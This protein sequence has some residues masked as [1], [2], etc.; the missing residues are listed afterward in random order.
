[1]LGRGFAWFDSGTHDSLQQASAFVQTI[2]QRQNLKI[3][4]LEEIAF[5]N[6]FISKTQLEQAAAFHGKGEYGRY[7]QGLLEELP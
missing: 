3:A 5:R 4:C 2:E 1:V 7:L 6:G